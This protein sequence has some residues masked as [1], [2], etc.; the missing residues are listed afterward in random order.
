MLEE[1]VGGEYERRKEHGPNGP[2]LAVWGEYNRKG[3]AWIK[4]SRM[5]KGG[6]STHQKESLAKST[7]K[8]SRSIQGGTRRRKR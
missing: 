6:C 5:E 7:G 3:G 1:G 4:V 8:N 2:R